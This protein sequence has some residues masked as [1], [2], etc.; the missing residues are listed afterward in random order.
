MTRPRSDIKIRVN[1]GRV[2]EL[3]SIIDCNL[4]KNIRSSRDIEDTNKIEHYRKIIN[5]ATLIGIVFVIIAAIIGIKEGY[6]TDQDKLQALLQSAGFLGPLV[7]IIIQIVQ[8]VIP[9]IPGGITLLIGV[10]VFGPFWG[11]VYN[12]VGIILGSCAAFYLARFYGQP[13]VKAMVKERTFNK[14]MGWLNKNQKKFNIFFFI[15]MVF[16]FFPDDL[17]CMIAGLSKMKFRQF[18]PLL[19]IGKIPST[20]VYTLFLGFA[21][22]GLDSIFSFFKNR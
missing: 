12:Y 14:Y 16:P 1:P 8:C 2:K 20:L 13:L 22:E 9:I 6:F 18:F 11:F 5:V 3:K 15:A 10:L 7:F 21:Y 19:A 4:E 17:I